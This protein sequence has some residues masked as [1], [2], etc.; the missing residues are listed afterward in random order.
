MKEILDCESFDVAI[1]SISK[2]F[3]C[4]CHD[5]L[6]LLNKID[7]EKSYSQQSPPYPANEFLFRRFVATFGDP[8][9]LEYVYW[10]HLTRTIPGNKF[11]EGI[12]P[13]DKALDSIWNTLFK[14]FEHTDHYQKLKEMRVEGGKNY[15]YTLKSQNNF[16]WGPFAMLVRDIAFHAAEVHNS[17]YLRLPEIIEDICNAYSDKYGLSIHEE[18]IRP[19]SP[20]IVKFKSAKRKDNGCIEAAIYYLYTVTKHTSW[21]SFY[22]NTCFEGKC[23]AIS[24]ESILNVEYL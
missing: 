18:V 6:E 19:L 4:G 8:K 17:D 14:I 2:I 7:L 1:S 23:I 13:L 3:D 22:G 9:E 5:I 16:H 10:F 24:P 15:H 12:L 20:C 21:S 11:V